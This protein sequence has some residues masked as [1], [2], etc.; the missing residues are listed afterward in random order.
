LKTEILGSGRA[1]IE[2]AAELLR[3]GGT[4]ALPTETV[5]G[6]AADATKSPAILR[7][8]EAKERPSFD[9][10]IVHISATHLIASPGLVDSLV[11]VGILHPD[12]TSAPFA[13]AIQTLASKFWPGP[14]TLILP[15]GPSIPDEAT[16]GQG[17]VGIRMP[18][19][20]LFQ[21]VLR[22]LS[23]PLAAP[24]ANRFGRISPTTSDHVRSELEGR[25]DAILDGGAC[26]VGVESTILSLIH[27]GQPAILRPGKISASEIEAVLQVKPESKAGLLEQAGSP[28][29][30]PG[31]LDQHYAPRKP[32]YLSESPFLTPKDL[33]AAREASGFSGKIGVLCQKPVP[34]A[35]LDTRVSRVLALS[36]S[37]NPD[38]SAQ[39]LFRFLRIL[40]ED[41]AVDSLIADLPSE[42]NSGL[43]AAIADRLNRAS[44]NKPL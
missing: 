6:L 12:C 15:K 1:D 10:L 16:S 11:S 17:T 13:G 42:R 27:P 20:P 3:S 4:V 35:N 36:P 18:A 2:R 28:H 29:L 41:P 7:I 22:E 25:I 8:F 21:S 40:D 19:H 23:F 39:N 26:A 43:E 32:L 31:M 30:A 9:P 5:Y 34:G 37:G 38:E 33:D 44:I 14:L 24:S